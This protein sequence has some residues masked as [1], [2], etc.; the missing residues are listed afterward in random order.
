MERNLKLQF[1][2]FQIYFVA[3][4]RVIRVKFVYHLYMYCVNLSSGTFELMTNSAIDF[5]L[6]SV[7][8]GYKFAMTTLNKLTTD[9]LDLEATVRIFVNIFLRYIR[10]L[11]IYFCED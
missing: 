11:F 8:T 2:N 9:E 1:G 7:C 6:E 4:Y 10:R 3:G 5:M